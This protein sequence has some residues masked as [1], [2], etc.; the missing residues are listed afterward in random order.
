MVVPT[1]WQLVYYISLANLP[2]AQ[3]KIFVNLKRNFKKNLSKLPL[4]SNI[5]K[6]LFGV[7]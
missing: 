5:T 6:E 7:V 4:T 3:D 1:Y 2:A